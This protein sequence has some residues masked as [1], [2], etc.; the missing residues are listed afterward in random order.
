MKRLKI[1]LLQLNQF[2][3]HY[4]QQ[5]KES[6]DRKRLEPILKIPQIVIKNL[7]AMIEHIIKVFRLS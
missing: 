1:Y 7:V 5:Q 6:I 4:G 3:T 2:Q